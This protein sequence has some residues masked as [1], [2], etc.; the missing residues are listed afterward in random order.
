MRVIAQSIY[1]GISRF[2][3]RGRKLGLQL[4]EAE[5]QR[6]GE[7]L[8]QNKS[9]A[10]LKVQ[11]GTISPSAEGRRRAVIQSDQCGA[12]VLFAVSVELKAKANLIARDERA[13]VSHPHAHDTLQHG[14]AVAYKIDSKVV[15]SDG[16]V[17]FQSTRPTL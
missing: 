4:F 3:P 10:G 7:G 11:T 1:H 14:V 6:P 2:R 9:G 15:G 13:F 8:R 5:T 12:V 17:C 16:G